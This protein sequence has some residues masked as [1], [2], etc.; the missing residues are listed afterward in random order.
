MFLNK[1]NLFWNKFT[2]D[3]CDGRSNKR[4]CTYVPRSLATSSSPIYCCRANGYRCSSI[5]S[6]YFGKVSLFRKKNVVWFRTNF[7][8]C[9]RVTRGIL[10]HVAQPFCPQCWCAVTKSS[11]STRIAS[12]WRR[13][14]VCISV[15]R[16]VANEV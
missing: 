15:L 14:C 3:N 11:N 9:V 1:K 8:L 13:S 4:F 16:L 5:I 2:Y 6:A 10:N 7:P 12:R